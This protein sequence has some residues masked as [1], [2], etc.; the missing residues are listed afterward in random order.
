MTRSVISGNTYLHNAKQTLNLMTHIGVAFLISQFLISPL[1]E[2]YINDN[3]NFRNIP[4]QYITIYNRV[5]P[6]QI[7]P[8]KMKFETAPSQILMKICTFGLRGQK[9]KF[10]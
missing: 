8:K 1:P 3:G 9:R 7:T 5:I 10:A 2:T 6:C 4:F